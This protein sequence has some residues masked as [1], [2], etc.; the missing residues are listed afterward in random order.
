LI[1][2]IE[3]ALQKISDYYI[4][5]E[6]SPYYAMALIL[7]PSRRTAGLKEE[8]GKDRAEKAIHFANKLWQR[9]RDLL[10]PVSS[11][12]ISASYEQDQPLYRSRAEDRKKKEREENVFEKIKKERAYV[13]RPRSQD[14]FEDYCNEASY[15]TQMPPLKWWQLEMQQKRWPRLSRLALEVLSMPAMSAEPERVF[16]GG[17]HS[18]SWDRGKLSIELLEK[19]ECQKSWSKQQFPKNIKL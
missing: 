1:P 9:Y 10:L 7:Q 19:L 4:K 17:R 11:L 15:D 6:S 18:M 3:S 8:W 12:S 14:E 2:R 13:T 5:L 16:S